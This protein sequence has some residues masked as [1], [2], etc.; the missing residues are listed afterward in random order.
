MKQS[1]FDTV[2]I[3][4]EMKYSKDILKKHDRLK[5]IPSSTCFLYRYG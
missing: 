3:S 2:T 1:L 5:N 4:Y